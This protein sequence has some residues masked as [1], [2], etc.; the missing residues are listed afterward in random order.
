MNLTSPFVM[1][2]DT[3]TRNQSKMQGTFYYLK[4]IPKYKSQKPYYYASELLPEQ[5]KFRS[6]IERAPYAGTITD[7]RGCEDLISLDFHGFTVSK[8]PS[9]VSNTNLKDEQ[10]CEK[11]L[12][13]VAEW[14]KEFMDAEL[15]L[16]YE[17]RV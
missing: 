2:L 10:A 17:Y 5:E 15:V 3:I 6:N 16:C 8:L 14:M 9:Q 11:F 4:D 7:V 13:A 1:D 12:L